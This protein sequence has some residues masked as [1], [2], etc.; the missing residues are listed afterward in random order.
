MAGGLGRGRHPG[1]QPTGLSPGSISDL[2]GSLV[3]TQHALLLVRKA[4]PSC[5]PSFITVLFVVQ[6]IK[7]FWR[8]GAGGSVEGERGGKRE[9]ERKYK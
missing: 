7:F 1:T 4:S 8:L 3:V 6:Q 5:F 2:A 9:T